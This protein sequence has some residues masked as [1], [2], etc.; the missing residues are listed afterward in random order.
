MRRCAVGAEPAHEAL[1]HDAPERGTEH[2]VLDPHI[3]K[4]RDGFRRAVRVQCREDEMAG[5]G[6]LHGYSG[7]IRVTDLT[8]HDHVRVVAQDG[9]QA[10]RKVEI[11]VRLHLHLTDPS[12][13]V[14]DRILDREN[15]DRGSIDLLEHG[16][17][18]RRL[19]RAGR[20]RDED[21]PIRL[22]HQSPEALN[23]VGIEAEFRKVEFDPAAVQHTQGHRF[24]VHGRNGGDAE[25]DVMTAEG[26][27][28]ASVLGQAPL[29]DIEMG[30]DFDAG[31][32]G[33]PQMRRHLLRHS[34]Q[35]VDPEA[36]N[37]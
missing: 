19:A 1:S 13:L 26:E 3:E 27:L 32:H 6:R 33:R 11:D 9:P 7:R 16:I 12:Q 18:R 21:D 36:H 8:D 23:L 37:E 14:F 31:D 5:E 2:E 28:D 25:I 22:C 10:G 30:H 4:P 29:R 15:L 20:T 35:P 17:E 24:P 34:Q